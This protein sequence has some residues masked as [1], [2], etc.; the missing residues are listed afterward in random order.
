MGTDPGLR[1]GGVGSALLG[2]VC[3][4]LQVAEYDTTEICWVGP[5]RFYAKNGA[6]VSRVFRQY[7]L[8]RPAD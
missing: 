5:V 4:D 8:R 3:R 7:R 6:T 2:Q 1:Q